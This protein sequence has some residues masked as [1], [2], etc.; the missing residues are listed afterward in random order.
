MI[1]DI[2]AEKLSHLNYERLHLDDSSVSRVVFKNFYFDINISGLYR[3]EWG[4]YEA[5]NTTDWKFRQLWHHEPFLEH[6][7]E[8]PLHPTKEE[9]ILWELEKGYPYP[10]LKEIL[11]V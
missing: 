10:L 4:M 7:F 3:K 9:A 11:T 6:F 5:T 1:E 8:N 2:L